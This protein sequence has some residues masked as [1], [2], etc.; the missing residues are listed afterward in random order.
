MNGAAPD[1]RPIVLEV[2]DASKSYYGVPAVSEMS[3]SVRQGETLAIIGP[4][5]AGKSTFFGLIAGEHKSSSGRIVF[6]GT[7]ITRWSANRRARFGMSRTFQVARFF[8][9]RTVRENLQLARVGR[10]GRYR[11]IVRGFSWA[12]KADEDDVATVL[13]DLGLS[14]IEDSLAANLAQGDRKRLEL[15]MAMVQRPKVLLLDEPTAGMS[16][17][18]CALTVDTLKRIRSADPAL[19]IVMTGHDME[20][21]FSLAQRIVLMADGRKVIDGSPEEIA[22]SEIA[23]RVY[24]GDAN[25]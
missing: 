21:L 10:T 22:S 7:E 5:G 6:D 1:E 13:D 14:H 19:T 12:A 15:A 9:S 8:P 20:V 11:D 16:N 23:R 3:L 25:E 4:N 2:I 18:D 24:L 17:E